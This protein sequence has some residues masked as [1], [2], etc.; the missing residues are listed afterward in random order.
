MI[1]WMEQSHMAEIIINTEKLHTKARAQVV[2]ARIV[3]SDAAL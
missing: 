1:P 2:F 3:S